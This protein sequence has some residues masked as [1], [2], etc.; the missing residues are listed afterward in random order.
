MP[1]P[2]AAST[3]PHLPNR[4]SSSS[5]LGSSTGS[6]S[7]TARGSAPP[8]HASTPPPQRCLSPLSGLSSHAG[9]EYASASPRFHRRARLLGG[10]SMVKALAE[11]KAPLLVLYAP[12]PSSDLLGNSASSATDLPYET[13]APQPRR[14]PSYA[15]ALLTQHQSQ[16][17][18]PPRP[19]AHPPSHLSVVPPAV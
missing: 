8:L 16:P 10:V 1:V 6:Q 9:P 17:S 3:P 19:R 2:I 12:S 18:L 14:H 4:H 7:S 15:H 13:L 11:A 5:P